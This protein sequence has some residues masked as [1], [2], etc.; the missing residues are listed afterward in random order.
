MLRKKS[1]NEVIISYLYCILGSQAVP[2]SVSS[3]KRQRM[4]EELIG[5]GIRRTQLPD[6]EKQCKLSNL[7]PRVLNRDNNTARTVTR[8]K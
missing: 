8:M 4:A 1:G 2:M 3:P 5:R 6:L 7:L